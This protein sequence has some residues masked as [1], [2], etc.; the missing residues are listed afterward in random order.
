M[1][2]ADRKHDN[3]SEEETVSFLPFIVQYVHSVN[4]IVQMAIQGC[5]MLELAYV[6][7]LRAAFIQSITLTLQVYK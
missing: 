1:S 3:L 2:N 7:R 6:N 5:S 4:F